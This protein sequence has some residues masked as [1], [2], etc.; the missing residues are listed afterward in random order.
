[1]IIHGLQKLTLLDYPGKTACTIF[2]GNCNFRCPYCHNQDLVLTPFNMN[3]ISEDTLF[4]FLKKRQGLLDGVCITGG[5]PLLH[6]DLLPLLSSIRDLGFSIKLDTNGS[7]PDRLEKYVRMGLLDYVAMDIKNSIHQ[8]QKTTA[9]TSIDLSSIN[10]S[11]Q[12][13]LSGKIE[14]EFRTTMVKEFHEEKDFLSIGQW[15]SG[16][17]RYFLQKFVDSGHLV[18]S[19]FYP[20]PHFH[21]FSQKEASQIQTSLLPFVPFTKLRGYDI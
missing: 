4:A 10:K 9:C 21:A 16:A 1:M 15:I 8:Y 14:Y 20:T 6:G 18:G 12:F 5:E 3:P 11:V 13:L 17:K 7:F 2:L 19:A